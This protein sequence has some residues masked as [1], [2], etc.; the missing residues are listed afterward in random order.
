MT[1][2]VGGVSVLRAYNRVASPDFSTKSVLTWGP[3]SASRRKKRFVGTAPT[4]TFGVS[5][6]VRGRR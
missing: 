5:R 2:E 4:R 1:I 3:I 6:D